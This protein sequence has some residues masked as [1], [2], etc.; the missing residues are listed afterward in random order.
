MVTGAS[1]CVSGVAKRLPTILKYLARGRNAITVRKLWATN[2]DPK[3]WNA[4]TIGGA[5]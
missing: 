1:V 3:V 2:F 5:G 4:Q